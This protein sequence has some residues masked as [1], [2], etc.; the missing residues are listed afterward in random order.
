MSDFESFFD[1]AERLFDRDLDK[2][3]RLIQ[4]YILIAGLLVA[5]KHSSD[6]VFYIYFYVFLF[7]A[8]NNYSLLSKMKLPRSTINRIIKFH[9]VVTHT[10]GI[11]TSFSFTLLLFTFYIDITAHTL[12]DFWDYSMFIGLLFTIVYSLLLDFTVLSPS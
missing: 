4:T 3:E 5:C 11:I 9:W 8:I 7:C 10:W 6:N 1:Q 2:K 12:Y